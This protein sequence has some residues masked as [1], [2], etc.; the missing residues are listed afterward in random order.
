M[1]IHITPRIF[2]PHR[3]EANILDVTID[4][5]GL[6]LKGGVDIKVC[7]PY[8]NKN[9]WIARAKSGKKAVAGILVDTPSHID[10][11]TVI[12][13]WAVGKGTTAVHRVDYEVLDADYQAVTDNMML[14]YGCSGLLGDWASRWPEGEQYSAPAYEQ[15]TM[16]LFTEKHGGLSR[17]TRVHD[18]L[19]VGGRIA[20]RNE[21]FR[22]PTVEADRI[23]K[24]RLT[25]I[26]IPSME[27]V[28]RLG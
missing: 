19:D 7:R 18:K 24:T 16:E 26:P 3:F 21:T 8:P 20:E 13:R 22:V 12:S 15:P 5:L 1:L 10:H 28:I 17:T 11:F 25:D 6:S 2:L 27:S 4:Q 14:W 23:I 9:Y